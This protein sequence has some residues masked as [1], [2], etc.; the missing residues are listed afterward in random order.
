MNLPA[1]AD[2]GQR[3]Q[4]VDDWCGP[5]TFPDE[6][7]RVVIV[8]VSHRFWGWN[9]QRCVFVLG[10]KFYVVVLFPFLSSLFQRF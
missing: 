7:E 4:L 6:R 5:A 9:F 2:P 8:H 1:N 10:C 3:T